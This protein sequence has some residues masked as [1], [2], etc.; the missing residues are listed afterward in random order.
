MQ[1]LPPAACKP[2]RKVDK[3]KKLI[4]LGPGEGHQHTASVLVLHGFGD[5][6][7]GWF[8]PALFWAERLPHARFVL[9]TAPF[10]ESMG[11]TSWFDLGGEGVARTFAASA[12]L[13]AELLLAEEDAVGAGR[14]VVA[15]FSQ[16]GA[17]AYH[18]GLAR[19]ARRDGAPA[20]AGVAALSTFLRREAVDEI[21][22]GAKATHVL[23]CHGTE[24]DRIPG[25]ADGARAAAEHLRKAGVADVDLKI[26]HGMGHAATE[27]ELRDI[28]VWLHRVLPGDAASRL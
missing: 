10:S 25:G 9:P 7:A 13:L 21:A 28:L 1:P 15:G 27:E 24:D 18:L 5:S 20:L 3:T 16:G 23:I 2:A 12:E 14:V 6:A 11:T 22:A 17:L 8:E 4:E 26:Y 19:R